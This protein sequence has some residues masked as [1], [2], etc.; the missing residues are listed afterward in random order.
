[1]DTN[2]PTARISVYVTETERD[3]IDRVARA[4]G[5]TLSGFV[6]WAAVRAAD[7]EM[8]ERGHDS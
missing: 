2:E 6:R 7:T 8:A 4:T 3:R 1:M 5:R